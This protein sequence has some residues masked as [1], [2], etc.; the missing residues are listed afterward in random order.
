MLAMTS[1]LPADEEEWGFEFKWDGVRALCYWDGARL[2]LESRNLLDITYRY[3]EFADLGK[4]LGKRSCVLDGEIVALNAEGRPDFSLLQR[5]M[6][7]GD[8]ASIESARR[9]IPTRYILFDVLFS[10]GV[11]TLDLPYRERRRI[12]E[13]MKIAHPR[14]RISPSYPGEGRAMLE[15]ARQWKLEGTMAKR[16]DSAYQ[17]GRR[18]PD[19]LKIKIVQKQ[20]FV[21]GG[22]TGQANASGRVGALLVGYYGKSA[23]LRYAGR[24]GTGFDATASRMLLE[25]LRPLARRMNPFGE[26]IPARGVHFAAPRLVAEVEFRRWPEEGLIQQGAYKGLRMDKLAADVTRESLP[27]RRAR[28]AA[29]RPRGRS[30]RRRMN[31]DLRKTTCNA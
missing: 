3:P 25:R 7:L 2:R 8:S 24:V 21:I 18:S 20:E 17:P 12:L 27:A 15:T 19:W 10:N 26:R 14:C 11:P 22:W 9:R 30:P 1:D 29:S 28:S 6:H 4:A 13:E 23:G 5:R 16:L 31:A